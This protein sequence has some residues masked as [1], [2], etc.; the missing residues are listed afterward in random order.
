MDKNIDMDMWGLTEQFK[1]YGWNTKQVKYLENTALSG[2][3]IE[4]SE[5]FMDYKI[6]ELK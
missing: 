2:N 5:I 6:R 4:K 3:W 1:T